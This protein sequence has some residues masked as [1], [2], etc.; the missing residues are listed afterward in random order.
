MS[1]RFLSTD[2]I[3]CPPF[4]F[5]DG[6]FMHVDLAKQIVYWDR[7]LNRFLTTPTIKLDPMKRCRV[8]CKH[9][10]ELMPDMAEIHYDSNQSITKAT[11]GL[12]Y[13]NDFKR[14]CYISINPFLHTGITE[15]TREQIEYTKRKR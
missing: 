9:L 8:I 2:M 4:Y 5:D 14:F 11:N 10:F 12:P 13:N 15:I 7:G 3:N 1:K 6:Q